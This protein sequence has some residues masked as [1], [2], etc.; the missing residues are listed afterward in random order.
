MH[1]VGAVVH[2]TLHTCYVLIQKARDNSSGLFEPPND[3]L[4]KGQ[5]K[6]DELLPP[7]PRKAQLICKLQVIVFQMK[8]DVLVQKSEV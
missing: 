5:L 3:Y 8:N 6:E 7:R 1:M 2:S 4:F